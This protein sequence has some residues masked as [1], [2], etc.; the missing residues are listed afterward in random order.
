VK[1]RCRDICDVRPVFG[2]RLVDRGKV[3][4]FVCGDVG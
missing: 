3:G 2:E 4:G 1:V